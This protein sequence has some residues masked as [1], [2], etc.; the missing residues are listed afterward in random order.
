M[1]ELEK[2][3]AKITG[4]Y[5]RMNKTVNDDYSRKCKDSK[6]KGVDGQSQKEVITEKLINLYLENGD[7][8]FDFLFKTK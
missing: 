3:K 6:I 4:F 8:C 7:A 5:S 1:S 2:G